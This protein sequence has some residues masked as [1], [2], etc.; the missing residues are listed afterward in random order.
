MDVNT[1]SLR[2]DCQQHVQERHIDFMKIDVEG[3]EANLALGGRLKSRG[4]QP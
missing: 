2:S 4:S 3:A 1:V